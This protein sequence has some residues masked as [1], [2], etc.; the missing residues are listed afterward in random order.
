MSTCLPVYLSASLSICLSVCLS[1]CLHEVKLWDRLDDAPEEALPLPQSGEALSQSGVAA[2][3]TQMDDAASA[4]SAIHIGVA[5]ADD[6]DAKHV[7]D[8]N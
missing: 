8:T 4:E 6:K 1:V 2:A 5:A 7:S 3:S